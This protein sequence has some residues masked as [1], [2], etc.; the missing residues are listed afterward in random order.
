MKLQEM[1]FVNHAKLYRHTD[2]EWE[3]RG[4]GEVNILRHIKSKELR[5][6][7]RQEQVLNLCLYH[8][9]NTDVVYK[10][11]DKK[12]WSFAAHDFSEGKGALGRFTLRFK[13]QNVA[14]EFNSAV[15]NALNGTA[16]AVKNNK[17][18][19]QIGTKEK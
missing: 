6:L 12:S 4:Q 5:V 10:P 19:E 11:M 18:L 7:M 2:G 1:L 9:L 8:T 13:N 17:D 14:Q 16:E 15:K 3:I